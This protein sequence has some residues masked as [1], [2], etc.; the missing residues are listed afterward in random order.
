MRQARNGYQLQRGVPKDVQP[1]IG[2]TIWVEA[3]GST[4]RVAQRLSTAFAAKTDRLIAE[5]RNELSLTGDELIDLVPQ[6]FDLSDPEIVEMLLSGCDVEV[7]ES[8]I[9]LDQAARYRAILKGEKLPPDH[10]SKEELIQQAKAL[11]SP[12]ARTEIAWK[13][14]LD[15]FL[16]HSAVTYPTSAS[17]QHA[18]AYRSSLLSRL[19]PSTVKTRLAFLCGLWSVLCELRPDGTHIF[20]GLNTRIKVVKARKLDVT[21]TDPSQWNGSGEQIEIFKFL[22]FTGA[23]LAEIAGLQAEDLLDDQ[24]LIRPNA[25]RPLKSDSSARSIPIHP[26]L[27]SL[28]IEM[29]EREGL[30]WPGQYQGANKRW[31]VNLSKPCRKI[32]GITPKGFRDRAATILR[33]HNMN[34]AVV[35]TLLGHTPNSISMAYGATPWSELKRAVNLL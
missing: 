10:L 18:I 15:D 24:I 29:R 11:K 30:L 20:K 16:A 13:T 25:L 22:Y 12:A 8:S 27:K 31:G 2:K 28:S 33:A 1:V 6:R 3:A 9:T 4:Y 5:A 32:V 21:I 19:S 17:R 14:A 35:V 7:E 23:R 34:E 26:R